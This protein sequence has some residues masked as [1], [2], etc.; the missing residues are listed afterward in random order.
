[1][2]VLPKV[3]LFEYKKRFSVKQL[4]NHKLVNIRG[5]NGSGKSSIPLS[6]LKD[7]KS[8][9]ELIYYIDN[10]ERV[11]AT[12]F[13]SFGWIALGGYRTKCGGLDGYRNNKQTIDSL[14]LVWDLD[15][16]IIME[17]V[18]ASTIRS[19]Y[20]EL[21]SS[22]NDRHTNKREILVCSLVPPFDVCLKRIS[23]RNGGKPIK[24]EQ[25]KQKYDVVTRGASYFSELGISSISLDN[26]TIQLEDTRE[27]FLSSIEPY[28]STKIEDDSKSP[29]MTTQTGLYVCSEDEIRGHDWSQYYKA[30]DK[31]VTVDKFGL[32]QF[33]YWI[34]ER[35]EIW[36][37]RVNL[38]LPAPWTD[39]E[40][41]RTYK[42]THACRDLDRL[43]IYYIRNLLSN[44]ENTEKSKKELVLNT[45]I[46]RL[47]CKIETWEL[48][49]YI[50]LDEW[51]E[52]WE[53]A[54]KA[55]INRKKSGQPV[56]TDAYFVYTMWT[57]QDDPTIH[58]KVLNALK[59]I[60]M[61]K[62]DLDDIYNH[63]VKSKNM[64]ELV[65]YYSSLPCVGKF[66]AYEFVCD[67]AWAKKYRN[68]DLVKWSIDSYTSVG[69]GAK[70]GLGYIFKESGNL[71]DIECII[72]LRSVVRHYLTEYGFDDLKLPPDTPYL[73][74]RCIEHSLCEYSKYRRTYDGTGRPRVKYVQKTFDNKELKL[75][76]KI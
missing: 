60:E 59:L 2:F 41:L 24:T 40:I 54:K 45:M 6:F 9:F 3:D 23:A 11:A 17:G 66:N 25:V 34:H 15:Y 38:E 42:F 53:A 10:K 4:T 63:V 71:S 20:G 50:H 47:F 16:N 67:F 30:P 73:D 49:G 74:M 33:F 61:W 55:V 14:D 5:T 27:W 37:K 48:I 56:F 35:Q 68:I 70:K 18:L 13:P 69:P 12:V 31:K 28:F 26:S 65:E 29:I 62:D 57:I 43:S 52:K 46:Y 64:R 1:M 39:D 58:D 51:N 44:L 22:V 36:N 19:T 8:A 75:G 72:Y 32:K 7:D 76:G 21:F